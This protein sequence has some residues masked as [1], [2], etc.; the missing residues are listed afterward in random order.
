[1]QPVI[2]SV[3]IEQDEGG[4]YQEVLHSTRGVNHQPAKRLSGS[5]PLKVFI[6]YSKTPLYFLY[7]ILVLQRH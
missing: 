1:M 6:G 3:L 7:P 5:L 2:H 4:H